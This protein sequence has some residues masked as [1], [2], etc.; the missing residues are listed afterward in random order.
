MAVALRQPFAPRSEIL[1]DAGLTEE[2]RRRTDRALAERVQQDATAFQRYQRAFREAN[3][4]LRAGAD[5]RE[6]ANA[7]QSAERELVGAV[8]EK[9]E[10]QPP[11]SDPRLAEG[12]RLSVRESTPATTEAR[13]ESS[14]DV[15]YPMPSAF[16]APHVAPPASSVDVTLAPY[17]IDLPVLPFDDSQATATPPRLPASAKEAADEGGETMELQRVQIFDCSMIPR[18]WG[19]AAACGFAS[20]GCAGSGCEGRRR[21]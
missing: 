9:R 11:A 6:M 8:P 21:S 1:D 7:V 13:N 17:H 20:Y 15:K 10:V 3:E 5:P 18:S 4:A 19:H 14:P 16:L 2:A 12:S